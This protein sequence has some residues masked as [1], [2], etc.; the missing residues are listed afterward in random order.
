MEIGKEQSKRMENL[1]QVSLEC[2]LCKDNNST[3]I[4]GH[5]NQKKNKTLFTNKSQ[6]T[7]Q[8]EK[9]QKTDITFFTRRND[10]SLEAKSTLL[11]HS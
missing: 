4:Q 7:A 6:E 11:S 9:T 10:S 3:Y 5:D 8:K 1:T 2:K